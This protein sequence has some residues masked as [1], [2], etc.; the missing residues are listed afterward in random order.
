MPDLIILPT[1]Y[2]P[3]ISFFSDLI[4]AKEVFIEQYEHFE[5]QTNRNRCEILAAN[6]VMKL[7]IPLEK[8][9]NKTLTKDIKISYKENWQ[10]Q[11]WRSIESAYNRSPFFE[12]YKDY[13]VGFYESKKTTFIIDLNT[14]LT[15]TVLKLL[16]INIH[17]KFTESYINSQTRIPIAIGTEP[18]TRNTK[19]YIQVFSNKH[20][21]IPNLSI[22]DLLFNCGP[23]SIDYLL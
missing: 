1:S 22:I 9:G 13:F 5:K 4:K 18:E 19:H 15:E 10:K 3:S 6:G 2:L 8:H 20:P 16:K 17:L 21:F 7:I 14:Q 11:H 12:F 23:Q